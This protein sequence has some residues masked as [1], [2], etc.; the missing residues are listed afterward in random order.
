MKKEDAI[1]THSIQTGDLFIFINLVHILC[2]FFLPIFIK[3]AAASV[4]LSNDQKTRKR[5]END[6]LGLATVWIQHH[7]VSR[8][9]MNHLQLQSSQG[10]V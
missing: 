6:G 10:D 8:L 1:F 5:E 4:G 3:D 7:L 2:R 9:M